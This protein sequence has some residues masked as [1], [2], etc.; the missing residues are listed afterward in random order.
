MPVVRQHMAWLVKADDE[1][2]V[3][4]SPEGM[5]LRQN[6]RQRAWLPALERPGCR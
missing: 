3:F 6:F 4:T 1:A 5:P 2:L